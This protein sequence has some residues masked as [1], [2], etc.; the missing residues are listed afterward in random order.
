[1]KMKHGQWQGGDQNQTQT[2]NRYSIL[3]LCHGLC[4]TGER[5][6]RQ[7]YVE[8]FELRKIGGKKCCETKQ[9]QECS[10]LEQL[11]RCNHNLCPQS[12]FHS[13]LDTAAY[14]SGYQIIT[15]RRMSVNYCT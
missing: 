5:G 6:A 8:V 3:E 4:S 1:M 13:A 10:L 12:L 15:Q 2:E 7:Q 11:F 9:E 14:P